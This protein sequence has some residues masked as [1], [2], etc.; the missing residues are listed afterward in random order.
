MYAFFRLVTRLPARQLTPP[1]NF[2]TA[3]NFVLWKRRTSEW[4]LLHTD[5]WRHADDYP[6]SLAT[7]TSAR[8]KSCRVT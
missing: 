7:A 4:G 6:P 2:L 3:N 1:D 8:S 5:I